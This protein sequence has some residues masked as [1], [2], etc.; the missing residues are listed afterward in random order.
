MYY[1][2][3]YL[4]FKYSVPNKNIYYCVR[5][6]VTSHALMVDDLMSEERNLVVCTQIF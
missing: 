2:T 3:Y 5:A 1:N 6:W 4:V